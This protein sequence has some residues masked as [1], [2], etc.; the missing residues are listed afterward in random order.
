MKFVENLKKAAEN[1]FHTVTKKTG[2]FVEDS[3]TKYSIFDLKN[4]IEKVYTEIGK[5]IYLASKEDRNVADFIE[6]KCADIDKLNA[7]IEELQK[8]LG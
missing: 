6:N 1:T 4:E 8:K 7:E 5:E 2:E 3:K